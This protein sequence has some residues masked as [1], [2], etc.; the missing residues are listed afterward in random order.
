MPDQ[1][2]AKNLPE[3]SPLVGLRSA[4][5][6]LLAVLTGIGAGVL[7]ALAGT[8]PAQAILTGVGAAAAATFFF[9]WVIAHH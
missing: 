6:L 7:T 9:H 5:I 4:V 8:H 1:D 3:Q 2:A